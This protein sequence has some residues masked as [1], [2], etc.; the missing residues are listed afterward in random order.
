M[1]HLKVPSSFFKSR[2]PNFEAPKG[3]DRALRLWWN[4]RDNCLTEQEI[5]D[6]GDK[7]TQSH[8]RRRLES[9]AGPN[10]QRQKTTRDEHEIDPVDSEGTVV[11]YLSSAPWRATLG[12]SGGGG[13]RHSAGDEGIIGDTNAAT[14]IDP[15]LESPSGFERRPRALWERERRH[16]LDQ[17]LLFEDQWEYERRRHDR[18]EWERRRHNRWEWERRRQDQWEFDM[19]YSRR[20]QRR[21]AP[22]GGGGGNRD[23]TCDVGIGLGDSDSTGDGW[24]ENMGEPHECDADQREAGEMVPAVFANAAS[25]AVASA[26][27]P[28]D[29]GDADQCE[30]GGAVFANAASSAVAS[31]TAP[32]DGGDADQCEAGGAVLANAA[33]SAVASATAPVDG[34]DSDQS[35][36]GGAVFTNAAASA[37]AVADLPSTI[38][39]DSAAGAGRIEQQVRL[40]YKMGDSAMAAFE[41]CTRCG[42]FTSTDALRMRAVSKAFYGLIR[43]KEYLVRV[44]TGPTEIGVQPSNLGS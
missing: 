23:P 41:M 43:A 2:I 15:L 8:K 39:L 22:G 10:A 40:P 1:N 20:A 28:A 25:S 9:N 30:A 3:F 17:R 7:V 13:D 37:S 14:N 29:G 33:S 12:R 35:E 11:H 21:A 5:K 44:F 16:Q 34:G 38:G 19:R 6:C 18:L 31:A 4:Q 26:T 27:A 42:S 32:A 24:E 36:A